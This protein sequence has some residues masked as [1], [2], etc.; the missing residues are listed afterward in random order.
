LRLA[1][2]T[3]LDQCVNDVYQ[4]NYAV[5]VAAALIWHY[6]HFKHLAPVLAIALLF[7]GYVEDTLFYFLVPLFNP[8]IKFLTKGETLQMASGQFLPEQISGWLGWLGRTFLGRNI[9]LDRSTFFALNAIAI[10]IALLLFC[11]KCNPAD[12]TNTR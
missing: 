3:P 1:G 2:W 5:V 9:A 10:L 7:C 12:K 6:T 11:K 8:A 4:V